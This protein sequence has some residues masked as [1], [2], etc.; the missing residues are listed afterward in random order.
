ML[1][2]AL[3]AGRLAHAYIFAGPDGCGRLTAALDIARVL[4]C[5]E[6]VSGYCGECR[7]CRQINEFVHPDVRFTIPGSRSVGPEDE[8]S[9]LAARA[10]DGITPLRFP[11]NTYISIEQIRTLETRLARRSFE[12]MGYVEV[13]LDAHLLRT[14]AA[15]AML[16]TLEEPPPGTCIILIT[17]SP[18]S[19]LPTVRSRAHTVRFGRLAVN[20]V[21]AVLTRRGMDRE[22][23]AKLAIRSDGRP[24]RALLLNSEEL[25]DLPAVETILSAIVSGASSIEMASTAGQVARE[26]G[27][28]GVL[29]LCS[30]L[31]EIAHEAR[32]IY[33]GAGHLS[34]EDLPQSVPSDDAVLRRLIDAMIICGKRVRGNVSPAM[35]LAAAIAPVPAGSDSL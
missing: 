6:S 7:H 11:G 20:A 12:G 3:K 4:M 28:E 34:R 25:E 29:T 1:H 16:K 23:A 33:S 35:A 10:A 30:Q 15:N 8:A 13:I 22:T 14:E 5:G 26:L 31:I 9:L 27:R 21:E 19:L 17:A 24:G 32:R 2:A 18:T